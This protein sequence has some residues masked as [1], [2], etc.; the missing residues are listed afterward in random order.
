MSSLNLPQLAQA[1]CSPVLK[2]KPD[3]ERI[4]AQ[5]RNG[6]TLVGGAVSSFVQLLMVKNLVR[7][8]EVLAGML[9]DFQDPL[10]VAVKEHLDDAARQMVGFN[11][12]HYA[13][14]ERQREYLEAAA[15]AVLAAAAAIETPAQCLPPALVLEPVIM[16]P[17]N[18]NPVYD[19]ATFDGVLAAYRHLLEAKPGQLLHV[20]DTYAGLDADGNLFGCSAHA[21]GSPD[22][23]C[24]F[25][26]ERRSW[27][28]E[29][30]CWDGEADSIET[31]QHV[32]LPV[33]VHF[34]PF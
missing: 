29:R 1:T 9:A 25:D 17:I 6:V 32:Y 14:F 8:T 11:T 18:P 27:D 28:S 20:G 16:E 13:P 22:M 24:Q 15:D 26:F 4:E 12:D 2:M 3:L 21:D 34:N 19:L 10:S 33:F 5:A 30:Q 31:A 23:D 7:K